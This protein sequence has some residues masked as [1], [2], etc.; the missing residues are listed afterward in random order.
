MA[1]DEQST[2]IIVRDGVAY[3]APAVRVPIAEAYPIDEDDDSY[4]GGTTYENLIESLGVRIL[5]QEDDDDYQGDS[6]LIVGLPDGWPVGFL[7]FGWGSCSGCDALQAADTHA[8]LDELRDELA[9]QIH[10]EETPGKLLAWLAV[11]DWAGQFSWYRQ[12]IREFLPKAA[13]ALMAGEVVRT[14]GREE[15]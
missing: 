5:L 7:T 4:V 10:W 15:D 6:Y 9:S 13:Q 12:T 2:D 11:R 8:D 3:A 1:Q 14:A